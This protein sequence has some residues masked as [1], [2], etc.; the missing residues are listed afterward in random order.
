MKGTL[1]AFHMT[2]LLYEPDLEADNLTRRRH[3]TSVS[4]RDLVHAAHCEI[5]KTAKAMETDRSQR[6]TH[7]GAH[8][9]R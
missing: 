1:S 2:H 8:Y 5:V 9:D 4:R 3:K 7:L 6:I